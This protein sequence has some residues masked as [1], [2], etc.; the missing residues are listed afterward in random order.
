MLPV[1]SC[2]VLAC[3]LFAVFPCSSHGIRTSFA[4]PAQRSQAVA[5]VWTGQG[6]AQSGNRTRVA[7]ARPRGS[8]QGAHYKSCM[9][10]WTHPGSSRLQNC[11]RDWPWTCQPCGHSL[12]TS[13]VVLRKRMCLCVNSCMESKRLENKVISLSNNSFCVLPSRAEAPMLGSV[14]DNFDMYKNYRLPYH[15]LV[16]CHDSSNTTYNAR[17]SELFSEGP[18]EMLCIDLLALARKLYR[19][20]AGNVDRKRNPTICFVSA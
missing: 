20:H 5:S 8:Q 7:G 3:W 14:W 11:A 9:W 13:E 12:W 2:L 4:P 6:S 18:S 15:S 10:C 16:K 19:L 1:I 17:W